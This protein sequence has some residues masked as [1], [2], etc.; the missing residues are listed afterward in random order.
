MEN[1]N[2]KVSSAIGNNNNNIIITFFF[3]LEINYPIIRR[4]LSVNFWK[5]WL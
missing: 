4:V 2:G 5:N 1:T 3:Y